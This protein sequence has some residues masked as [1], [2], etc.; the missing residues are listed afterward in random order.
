MKIQSTKHHTLMVTKVDTPRPSERQVATMAWGIISNGVGVDH[1]HRATALTAI[2]RSSSSYPAYRGMSHFIFLQALYENPFR[3][4]RTIEL[5]DCKHD[6]GTGLSVCLK[7]SFLY[8]AVLLSVIS[9]FHT[10][11]GPE[12][13]FMVSHLRKQL[14]FFVPRSI[15]EQND[16]LWG[17]LFNIQESS[18][19]YDITI[20][21][22]IFL[23]H[24]TSRE[25]WLVF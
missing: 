9:I 16:R 10:K 4:N 7:D 15:W 22:K 18:K 17:T 2:W 3:I 24:C 20:F 8:L 13:H 19:L 5:M 21:N 14:P 1:L 6:E 23:L 25:E 12:T 11:R